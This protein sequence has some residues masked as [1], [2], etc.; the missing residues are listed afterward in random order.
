MSHL[1]QGF[2]YK[3]K[4]L[5]APETDAPLLAK[6]LEVGPLTT[7][8][9]AEA[10]ANAYGDGWLFSPPI[11]GWTLVAST[12]LGPPIGQPAF[13]RWLAAL[14]TRIGNPVYYFCTHRVVELHG[15]AAAAEGRVLR[16]YAYLGERDEVLTDLGPVTEEEMDLRQLDEDGPDAWR[17]REEAVFELAGAWS[18]DPRDLDGVETES[19]PWTVRAT[20]GR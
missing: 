8:P 15:W 2:G 19:L 11:D 17:P 9:W 14:S 10:V 20:T 6:A 7:A 13:A 1:A 16:A 5:A 3:L 18:I 4:W 12:R